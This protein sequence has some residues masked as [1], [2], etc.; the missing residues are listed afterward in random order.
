MQNPINPD[1]KFCHNRAFALVTLR[2]KNIS[3]CQLPRNERNLL[4]T[5]AITC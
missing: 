1:L 5:T 4:M 2:R 3:A